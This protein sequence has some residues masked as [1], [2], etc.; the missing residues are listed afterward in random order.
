MTNSIF[1]DFQA[2]LAAI[3]QGIMYLQQELQDLTP[4]QATILQL[5]GEKVDA[6]WLRWPQLKQICKAGH[7]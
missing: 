1:H 2:D 5:M 3:S 7:Q 6:I 4:E